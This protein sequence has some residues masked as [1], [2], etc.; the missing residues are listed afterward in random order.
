MA[1]DYMLDVNEL[2]GKL[3]VFF[4]NSTQHTNN[5]NLSVLLYHP[6]K[7]VF[8]RYISSEIFEIPFYL[9]YVFNI[10]LREFVRFSHLS[11]SQRKRK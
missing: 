7:I 4:G 5:F 2:R 1:H 9:V 6:S 11:L 3:T 8:W 10:N